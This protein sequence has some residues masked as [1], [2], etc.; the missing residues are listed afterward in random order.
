[1]DHSRLGKI[2]TA[3]GRIESAADWDPALN[4]AVK[5]AALPQQIVESRGVR[6]RSFWHGVWLGHPLHPMLVTIPIGT[7]TLALALDLSSALGIP[8]GREADRAS[9]LALTA[10]AVGAVGAAVAGITD[11]RRIHGRDRRTGMVHGVINTTALA[12]TVASIGLRANGRRGQGRL[13]SALGWTCMFAGSYLGSHLVFRR[14]VGVDQADRGA[15]PRDF[16]AVIEL[17]DLE[18]DKPRKVEVWDEK[19]RRQVKIVLVRR[20]DQV[21]ALGALCSHM[22]GP[23]EEGW[24]QDGALVCPWHGSRYDL[25][26]GRP[27]DG[28]ST[29]P[30]PRYHV[31]VNAGIVELKRDQEPGEDAV[32]ADGLA[33]DRA[34]AGRE[35][36][37]RVGGTGKTAVEV[38]FEH[39]EVLRGLLSKL[40]TMSPGDPG[41]RDCLRALAVEFE[42][43]EVVEEKIFY[44]AVRRVSDTIG[45]AYAQHNELDDV[46]AATLRTGPEDPAFE[47][48]VKVLH[49]ALDHHAGSEERTMFV[50]AL[51]IGD[52][53]LRELGAELEIAIETQRTSRLQRAWRPMKIKML[54]GV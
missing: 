40:V 51:R 27:K 20:G 28:P 7:W 2:E 33:H 49:A 34:L 30:Q 16:L 35:A 25:Q 19:R 21:H 44:P 48:R 43:H 29:C 23:L 52:A 45:D 50:D 54:E 17:A 11:W 14:R 41:R 37:A 47:A 18:Q 13:V 9:D 12:L 10:G 6:W 32:T 31:R 1:M 53:R 4:M 36:K 38:L 22:G 3:I 39:H 15:E 24:V 42:I 46:F 8:R 26:T 5:A